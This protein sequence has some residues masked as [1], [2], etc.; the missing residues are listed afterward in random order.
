MQFLS[1]NDKFM[2]QIIHMQS[3]KALLMQDSLPANVLKCR[4]Y[5]PRALCFKPR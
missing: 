4:T 3:L 2:Y 5:I 1:L